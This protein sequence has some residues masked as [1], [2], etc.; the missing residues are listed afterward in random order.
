[1]FLQRDQKKTAQAVALMSLAAV[2]V[3][4][5]VQ[6]AEASELVKLARLVLTGKRVSE[7]APQKAQAR[8]Q[9][10]AEKLAQ[11]KPAQRPG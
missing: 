5:P 9:I 4:A 6:A 3:F 1:M 8:G 10:K 2:L 7:P 11:A